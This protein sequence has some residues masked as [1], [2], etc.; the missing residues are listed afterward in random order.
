MT[1]ITSLSDNLPH[2]LMDHYAIFSIMPQQ[3]FFAIPTINDMLADAQTCQFGI[4]RENNALIPHGRFMTRDDAHA[5]G[6][7]CASIFI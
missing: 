5:I 2:E 4:A 7:I 6:P 1:Q 3:D